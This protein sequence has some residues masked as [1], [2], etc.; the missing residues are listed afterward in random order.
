MNNASSPRMDA[1]QVLAKATTKAAVRLGLSGAAL[2]RVLGLSESTVS[3]ILRGERPL[4]PEAKEGELATLLVRVHQLL[5]ARVG[6]RDP[7][8]D[9]QED[10]NDSGNNSDN[11]SSNMSSNKG[12]NKDSNSKCAAWMASD[13]ALLGGKPRDLVQ[14]VVGLVA[15]V[16]H[17]DGRRELE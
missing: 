12:S 8:G 11:D 13:N 16:N 10:S 3:R 9:G 2:A 15:T 7:E 5:E 1:A 14:T 6:E 4:P 17:L